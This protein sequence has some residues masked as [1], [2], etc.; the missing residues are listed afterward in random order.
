MQERL[1][2]VR[3]GKSAGAG[4]RL[5][6]VRA[7]CALLPALFLAVF[8]LVPV[9]HVLLRPFW[10]G[11]GA[12]P[13]PG[14]APES[15]FELIASVL[16][17]ESTR[18]ALM[19][20]LSESA[21]ATA[22]SLAFGVPLAC[23]LYTRRFR[24][25]SAVQTLA[26]LPFVLPTVVVALAFDSLT[27]R[28]GAL[29][30]LHLQNS[31]TQLALALSFF[32]ITFVA[33]LIGTFWAQLDRR[34]EEAARTLGAGSLR[35][36]CT[37]TLP[38]LKPALASATIL[39]FLFCAS[40]FGVVLLLGGKKLANLETEIYTNAIFDVRLDIAAVLSGIQLI[41]MVCAL[42][43]SR[44]FTRTK[45]ES[46][47]CALPSFRT[48]D[49]PL[50]LWSLLGIVLIQLWPLLSLIRRSVTARTGEFTLKYYAELISPTEQTVLRESI[51][52]SLWIS[53]S[54][55]AQTAALTLLILLCVLCF[56]SLTEQHTTAKKRTCANL[57]HLMLLPL[58][59]SSVTLGFGMLLSMNNPLGLPVDLRTNPLL[60][61]IAQTLIALPVV[62]QTVLPVAHGVDDRL[63]QLARTLGAHP[64]RIFF[65]VDL[66]LMRRALAVAVGFSFAISL[67]EFGAASFLVRP[68]SRTLPVAIA[69]LFSR[70]GEMNY[71]TAL[72]ATVVLA[73][74]TALIIL[75]CE[76]IAQSRPTPLRVRAT[77]KGEDRV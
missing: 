6:L 65:T 15:G 12:R 20:T 64:V 9:G 30:L 54:I 76:R 18:I 34:V 21:A 40:N 1:R 49:I 56:R 66:S 48:R 19:N 24:G 62:L 10:G 71:G 16:T 43:V 60:I 27:G 25:A 73:T 13:N 2:R 44:K 74:T 32:N 14:A 55:A 39:V 31:F 42:L 28:G 8:F 7:A 3:A 36:F 58:G 57:E 47:T 26:M 41:F 63:R 51:G 50:L 33:R 23:L 22:I 68:D 4:A 38:R 45:P 72:A 75:A 67:G 70:P 61:P 53:F 77:S 5:G 17:E 46:F 69:H 59:V 37:I 35:V 52:H 11:Q 29:E